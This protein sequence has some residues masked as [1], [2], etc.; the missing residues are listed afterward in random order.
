MA[1]ALITTETSGE[2][3]PEQREQLD[4]NYAKLLGEQ[5]LPCLDHEVCTDWLLDRKIVKKD[6]NRQLLGV[7]GKI[8]K[9]LESI[10]ATAQV[11]ALP[12]ASDITYTH[13]RQIFSLL[14]KTESASK[15]WG[16]WGGYKARTS[17]TPV[18][19]LLSAH[20]PKQ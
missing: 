1:D 15:S 3:K 11:G 9:A 18:C 12:S 17:H 20:S 5:R 4:V 6:W 16:G 13:S 14:A 2:E 7:R 8:T 19:S 10:P